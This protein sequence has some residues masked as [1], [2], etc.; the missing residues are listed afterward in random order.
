MEETLA[1]ELTNR[2]AELGRSNIA[3]GKAM[4]VLLIK[5]ERARKRATE[6]QRGVLGDRSEIP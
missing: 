2:A 5:L 3:R 4:F 1:C 6:D